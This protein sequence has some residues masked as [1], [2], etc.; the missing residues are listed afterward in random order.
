MQLKGGSMKI[1][2]TSVEILPLKGQRKE[3]LY[4]V[5]TSLRKEKKKLSENLKQSKMVS[6]T[7][8]NLVNSTSCACF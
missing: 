3:N 4:A 7:S 2:I 1:S 6:N 8:F 5:Q